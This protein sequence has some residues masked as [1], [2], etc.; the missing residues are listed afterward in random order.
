MATIRFFEKPGCINNTKQ[1]KLLSL[2]GHEVNAQNLLTHPWTKDELLSFLGNLPLPKWFNP[3][4]PA[5]TRG[6]FV[7][8][9]QT[10]DSAINAMLADP[11]LI[12]RP[13]IE[14]SGERLVGFDLEAIN[15][16]AAL[17]PSEDP[18]FQNLMNDNL[19]DCPQVAKNTQCD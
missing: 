4:A 7:P 11:L 18:E 12:R 3:T 2:A 9:Q 1:K 8:T 6:G 16:I 15:R 17:G 19:V 13:L 14:I 5:I 10:P